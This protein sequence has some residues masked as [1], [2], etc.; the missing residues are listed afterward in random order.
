MHIGLNLKLSLANRPDK[1]KTIR[2][3]TADDGRKP[4]II[5]QCVCGWYWYPLSI[6]DELTQHVCTK[7]V[8]GD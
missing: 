8:E 7:Q 5:I 3:Q 1:T 2:G 6:Q 4:R